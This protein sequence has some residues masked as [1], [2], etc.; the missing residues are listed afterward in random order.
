MRSM[1]GL[2]LMISLAACEVREKF[3]VWFFCFFF[4]FVDVIIIDVCI[5]CATLFL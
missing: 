4:V 3:F 2:F 5:I 1:K